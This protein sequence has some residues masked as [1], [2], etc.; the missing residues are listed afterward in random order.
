MEEM[1]TSIRITVRCHAGVK[2]KRGIV[3]YG[4]PKVD[5]WGELYYSD[6]FIPE[7]D[8]DTECMLS[9]VFNKRNQNRSWFRVS[10]IPL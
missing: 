10:G 8:E 4:H 1:R 6:P 5:P 3:Y 2:D 7:I 9:Y